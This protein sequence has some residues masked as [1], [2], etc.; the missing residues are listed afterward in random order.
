VFVDKDDSATIAEYKRR[1]LAQGKI[2]L[3]AM[4]AGLQD[5]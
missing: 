1:A 4:L 5:T 2:V 3:E